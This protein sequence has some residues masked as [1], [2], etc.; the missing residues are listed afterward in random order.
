VHNSYYAE[1]QLLHG[2]TRHPTKFSLTKARKVMMRSEN[3]LGILYKTL[4]AR[5]LSKIEDG[6]YRPKHVVFPLPIKTII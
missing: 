4:L 2:K 1:V 3:G 6:R 5:K